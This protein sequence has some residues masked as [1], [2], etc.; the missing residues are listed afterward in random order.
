MSFHRLTSPS[1]LAFPTRAK[2]D[3]LEID[4]T[5]AGPGAVVD[6]STDEKLQLFLKPCASRVDVILEPSHTGE[7]YPYW[8][9]KRKMAPQ[10]RSNGIGYLRLGDDMS[11]FG[12]AFLST[13]A[14]KLR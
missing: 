13:D 7:W 11:M 6:I 5:A 4:I 1:G 14:G 9:A 8:E 12:C 2:G 10:F 3:I